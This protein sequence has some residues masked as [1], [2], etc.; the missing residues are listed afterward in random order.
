MAGGAARIEMSWPVLQLTSLSVPRASRVSANA[1]LDVRTRQWSA[2]LAV[3]QWRE[4]SLGANALDVRLDAEGNDREARVSELRVAL[5]ESVA[6]AQGDLSFVGQGL[7]DVHVS[8]DWLAHAPRSGPTSVQRPAGRWHLDAAVT[9]QIQPV[10]LE[11]DA[12]LAGQSI[13]LGK[14][15]VD[16]VEIPV[17]VKADAAQVEATT[18]PFGLLGGQWQLTGRYEFSGRQTG[19][20]VMVTDLSLAAVAS[21]AGLPLAAGA[22]TQ[23]LAPGGSLQGRAYAGIGLRMPGLDIRKVVATGSWSARDINIPPLVAQRARGV[24][25]IADGLARLEDIQLEQEGGRARAGLSFG[26]DQPQV[27]SIDLEAHEWPVPWEGRP[28]TA[29]VD[30]QARLQADIVKKT[31]E[32]Q[33]RLT[34]RIVWQD[35]EFA[36]IRLAAQVQG[37]TLEVREFHAQTLGGAADGTAVIPLNRWTDSV[38]RLQWQGIVPGQL[39]AW[40]GPLERFQGTMSGSLVV[41]QAHARAGGGSGDGAE[42]MRDMSS[43]RAPRPSGLAPSSLASQA[44]GPSPAHPLG[45]MRF[46]LAAN[47][48]QGR[49]GPAEVGDL[50][51]L[52]YLDST[53][54][55]VEDS[56]LDAFG[57]RLHA[58]ARFSRHLGKDY[59]SVVADFNDLSLDEVV[60][61]LDPNAGPFV[62]RL[63]GNATVLPVLDRPISLAGE[64]RLS[65]TQSD[66]VGSGIVRTLYDTLNLSFGAQEPTGAGEVRVRFEGPAVV[67]SSAQYFNRGVEIR[68][69]GRIANVNLGADS[70]VEGYAVGSTRILKGIKLPGVEALDRLLDVFQ[71]GAASVRIGGVVDNVE[72]KVVPL[73]EVLDPFRRL[74]WAQLRE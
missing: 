12:T 71:T 15:W 46:V 13:A 18:P 1:R 61:V 11:A 66:L 73:P 38:A 24:L 32:G 62:G 39:G 45:P 42:G 44:P 28:V 36:D 72:V 27:V 58:R 3:E 65:L 30:G 64:G 53:R 17:R 74:L 60:H 20:H 67:L 50:R 22:R 2:R 41:E 51:I 6:V 57:G 33:T 52:G 43:S 25:R 8:A 7:H 29:V 26:L 55:L 63:S 47:L 31:A 49:F 35:R 16:R 69:A 54:L 56:A 34:G 19:A 5:G 40:L 48:A 68:G 4:R 37:Q 23:N 21:M 10:R 9:G 59:G 70:P 14:R